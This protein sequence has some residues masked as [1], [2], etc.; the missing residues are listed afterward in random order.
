[1]WASIT[2]NRAPLTYLLSVSALTESRRSSPP[3]MAQ[4]AVDALRARPL[5]AAP[6]RGLSWLL[7]KAGKAACST[8]SAACAGRVGEGAFVDCPEP[9]VAAVPNSDEG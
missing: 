2:S 3:R 5:L 1:S 6:S 4:T 9:G 7:K 8:G